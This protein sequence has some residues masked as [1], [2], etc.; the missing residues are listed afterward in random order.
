MV[1][2]SGYVLEPL[3]EGT[4]FTLYR[5]RAR[6]NQMPVLAV[7]VAADQPPPQSLRRLEHEY[8]LAT[9]L[10]A[11][12]AAQPMELTRHQGQ[13]VLILKDPGGEPL[14]RV[15]EQHKGHPLDLTHF[16]RIAIGLAA[17]LSR[18]HRQGLI[19]RDVKPAHALADDSGNV[20]LTGF[21]LASRLPRERLTPAPPEIIDGTLAYMAPEQ[22]GRMNRSVDSRSDLYSLGVTFYELLVGVLPFTASDS[23]GWVHCHIARL[24]D[25][26]SLRRR[27]IPATLSNIVLKLLAKT[28]EERYQTAEG[29][30]A[31]LRRCLSALEAHGRIESFALGARDVPDRLLVPEKLYGREKEIELLLAAFDRVVSQGTTG[32]VLVS[33]FSGVG[34]SSVVHELH[35]ALVPPRALFASGKCDQY[36]RNTPYATLAQAFQTL[37]RQI[38]AKSEAEVDHWRRAL[39]DALGLN[40]QLMVNLIPELEFV[41]GK[42][43][44]VAELASQEARAR[45]Q[46]V[47]LRFLAVFAR[48]E[49]PLVLF[50]DDL[51]WLDT[52]SLDFLERLATNPDIRQVLLIGAYRDNEVSASHPLMETLAAIRNAG[53]RVDEV[54]LAPLGADDVERL[55]VDALRGRL[56]SAGPLARLVHEKTGGNP[57]F[58]IQLLTSLAEE[59]LLRFDRDAVGWI[60][61]VDRIRAKG[62]S[63]NV[64]DLMLGKLRR[65]P[66][67]TQDALEHLASLGNVAEI[68]L[69]SAALGQSGEEVD[70]ALL[71]A[72]RAGLI[73]R[74]EQSYA[75]LHDRIQEAAYALVPESEREAMHLRVG[76]R[77]LANLK[78]D[79]LAEHLFDVAGQ[80]NSG[81]KQLVDPDEKAQAAALNLRAGRKAKASAAYASALKYLSAGAELLGD[82]SWES[83]RDLIFALELERAGCEFLIG[84]LAAADRRL[85]GLS[86]HAADTVE[87][88]SLACLHIDV[89][90]TLDQSGRAIAVALDFLR[91]VGIEW[92][93]HPTEQEARQE[94]DRTWSLLRDREIEALLDLP[95][96]TDPACAGTLDVLERSLKTALYTDANL[97]TLLVCGM[98]KI[99]L[100]H[101]HT[102]ASCD[103]YIWLGMI[104]GSRFGDYETGFRL[105]RLG[106]DLVEKRGLE[107]FKAHTY[108]SFAV[109]IVP[110]TKHVRTGQELI[111]RAF[112]AANAIGDLTTA[113][114]CGVDVFGN[115]LTRGDPLVDVQHRAEQSL[116]FARNARFGLLTDISATQL[117]LIRTLRGLTPVFGCFD[118]AHFNELQIESRLSNQEGHAIAAC[119][120]WVRK[121]Q[122]R[123]F[124]GDYSAAVA[125]SSNAQRLLWT[126]PSFL[127]AADAHFYGA[128][129]HAASC[130][131]ALPVQYREHLEA[132]AAHHG[133][134]AEWA[135]HC[136][137]N[138]ENRALLVAAEI[139]RIEGRELDAERLYEG[140]IR[141]A[142]KNGF[143]HNEALASELAARFYSAR[144]LETAG[145]A[146]LRNAWNCYDRW[147]AHGKVKQLEK[148]HSS[149]REERSSAG[150]AK[151]GPSLGEIDVEAVVKASQALSS[152]MVLPRLI[153][154]LMRIAVE[155]AGAERGLLILFGDSEP[156]IKAEATTR[157]DRVDVQVRETDISPG[158]LPKSALHYVVR[159]QERV[160]LDDASVRHLY[161]DDEYFERTK[162]K[163]VLCL[164]IVK[165]TKLIGVLYLENNLASH[166][167]TSGR[168]AVL[169]M[170]ASQAAISLENAALYTDLQLQVGLLQH[171]PVSAWTLEPDGTPDFVNRVWLEFAGQTPDFVRS[172]PEAW[173]TAIHPEDREMAAKAFWEGVHSGQG[174]AFE[175]RSLSARDGTYRWH[176]QQAVVLR[177]AEGRVLKFVGT[178]TDIDD[179]KRT[180]EALRQAQGDL[181]RINRVTTMGEL[182]ASLAHE[183]SQP[184]SGAMTNASVCLRYLEHDDPAL[185]EV[186][187]AV[188]RIARDARRAAEVIDRIRSQFRKGSLNQE[189]LAVSEILR[190]TIALLRGEVM[191]YNISVRT[192]L[193]GDLPQI[194]GDRVQ[195][196]QVVM[197]LIV[198]SI[199]AMKDVDGPREMVVRSQ[200]AD[201]GQILVSVSDTGSGLPPG[202]AEQVFDPFFTTKP[203]GTGMGLRIS[204]SIIES[205]GG[206]LWA[207]VGAPGRGATFHLSLPAASPGRP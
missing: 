123:F 52:A 126:S 181:A 166:V 193:A 2:E 46:L 191:R 117:A 103:G 68:T 79:A 73:V 131:A 179:Q 22:T 11:G 71:E 148:G 43:P 86:S 62:Y 171:L 129:S 153:E 142:R 125:A 113:A 5:G 69:L 115:L 65:L 151:G 141:S 207:V 47:F 35:K 9:E 174:F 21:G 58:A 87:R 120:Y 106:Y 60:W 8:S 84:E 206:R 40:G 88:A 51:Q 64:V 202:L 195:L 190:D 134:L 97:L 185:D 15:I 32:L 37:V 16:L 4:D 108:L 70:A 54:V 99:S 164:P 26:P 107:R 197:N 178:T 128:L 176:L 182:A 66:R 111:R 23:M 100:K 95:L 34:K 38:L 27:E 150:S 49:H 31:D 81:A 48:P 36:K 91:H 172:H 59:G 77:L 137:E 173:M 200:R 90:T 10:D 183:V 18:A 186:R 109:L 124:A 75:F 135:E 122:A 177:D 188:S 155:H 204:R 144:G 159:T 154:Q 133:Q 192:D 139:A 161:S 162:A 55:T 180:E 160:V 146:C 17:A 163:S 104:A 118:D 203:H 14:D 44:P 198:N 201:D 121:L 167:F 30:E 24:P 12:W 33:G 136:P 6:A 25:A 92:S 96:M 82:R 152:E 63:N 116:D 158:D 20:W 165:Q 170:L 132:L 147:G 1:E 56:D 50:L 19:H 89:C 205:H 156:K 53:T 42:Q 13:T 175:T 138:F 196:Q 112:N 7:A 98:A 184:I 157:H 57:F 110:W 76:R 199:E 93:P 41:I 114:S 29:V 45:F 189:V 149:L 101:G 72:V 169:Q 127:E 78:A 145:Y 74:L 130:D 67:H 80:F 83:R 187:A 3:R 168:L 28:P 39:L 143:V 85:T 102:G 140:A 194:V 119:W 94:Y 61:D 105:G